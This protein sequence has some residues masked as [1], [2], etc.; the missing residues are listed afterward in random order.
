KDKHNEL[1][2]KIAEQHAA[3]AVQREAERLAYEATS[4]VNDINDH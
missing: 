2:H 4:V 1:Y 3:I